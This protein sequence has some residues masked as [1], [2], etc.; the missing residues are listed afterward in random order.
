MVSL[1]TVEWAVQPW[2]QQLDAEARATVRFE[3]GRQLQIDFGA[4]PGG[5]RIWKR[6]NELCAELGR[7]S[8]RFPLRNALL[9]ALEDY[10]GGD[11]FL[12]GGAGWRIRLD[13]KSSRGEFGSRLFKDFF[14]A[15]T[16]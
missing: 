8:S 7:R 12:N 14:T 3:T 9:M 15:S 6:R 10:L 5:W 2:R 13:S 16:Q 11:R 4:S 1:R